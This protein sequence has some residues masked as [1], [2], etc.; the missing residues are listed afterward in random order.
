MMRR[1]TPR[2]RGQ[3]S[4]RTALPVPGSAPTWRVTTA[5]RIFGIAIVVG[6]VLER[7]AASRLSGMLLGLCIVATACCSCELQVPRF[8]MPWISVAEGLMVGLLIGVAGDHIEPLLL[9]LAI[10]AVVAGISGGRMGTINTWLATLVGLVAAGAAGR[11]AGELSHEVGHAVVWLT[12]GL[13]AGLLAAHQARSLRRVETAQAPYAAAHRLVGQLHTLM[14]DLPTV[15]DVPTQA[16]AIADMARNAATAARTVVLVSSRAGLEP[17]SAS[18]S[19]LPTDEAT[20]RLCAC[21]GQ[22]LQRGNVVAFP[23][24]VGQ[25][26]IGALVLGEPAP[27]STAQL[28]LIQEQLDE[29]AIRMETAML[30]DDVRFAATTEERNRLARDIHDGLAQRVVSL[31]YLVD[32]VAATCEDPRTRETAEELRTEI[33]RVISELRYSVFDLRHDLDQAGSVSGALSE[34]V[35][36][37]S[38]HS[39]LRVHL[40]LDER[41]ARISRRTQTELLHIAKEAIGNVHKHARAINVWVRLTVAEGEVRL[42]VEDDGIGGAS[43]RAG[44]YGLHTM[45]ERAARIDADLEFGIRHDGGTIVTLRSRPT[46]TTMLGAQD[47]QRLARR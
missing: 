22:R 43:P 7:H 47:D 18:G 5:V 39:D 25:H 44:H 14:H 6:Q 16:E 21:H 8:R 12:I 24:R 20:G 9:Y 36:E 40:T 34:Y 45:R 29:N 33:T 41:G 42:V 37:L 30:V 10:P 3:R 38:S 17:V 19:V 4:L 27:L 28:D 46:A 1:A 11:D 23:L 35:R 2:S 32:E 26:I 31:G 13:G 15:F